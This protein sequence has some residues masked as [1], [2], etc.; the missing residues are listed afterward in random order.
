LLNATKRLCDDIQRF[1]GNR[2][3]LCIAKG[4]G[5]LVERKGFITTAQGQWLCDGA[6]ILKIARPL[7]LT[8]YFG[9]SDNQKDAM[10][11]LPKLLGIDSKTDSRRQKA[12]KPRSNAR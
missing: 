2:T 10:A 4:I 6:D 9:M 11:G 3:A 8:P 12:D 7:E 5:R 1:T